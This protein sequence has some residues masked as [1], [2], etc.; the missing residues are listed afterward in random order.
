VASSGHL[1]EG[2]DK[3]WLLAP[4]DL[5]ALE[6]ADSIVFL[7]KT[8][9]S[10]LGVIGWQAYKDAIDEAIYPLPTPR[11]LAVNE[12]LTKREEEAVQI[13][14]EELGKNSAAEREPAER[15]RGLAGGWEC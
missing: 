9:P 7:P 10:K 15:S 5:L 14:V 8:R 11:T 1:H 13:F 6:P 3:R 12:S 2:H 4:E